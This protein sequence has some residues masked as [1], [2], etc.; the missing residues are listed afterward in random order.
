MAR[1]WTLVTINQTIQKE[2]ADLRQVSAPQA[3][4]RGLHGTDHAHAVSATEI[5]PRKA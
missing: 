5:C 2:D 4:E 1:T 3:P